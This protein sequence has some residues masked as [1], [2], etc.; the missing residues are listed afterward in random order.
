MAETSVCCRRRIAFS[1]NGPRGGAPQLLR[2]LAA[3]LRQRG[4]PCE[5]HAATFT[6]AAPLDALPG[7]SSDTNPRPALQGQ[8]RAEGKRLG[9]AGGAG[10]GLDPGQ[11][12][13]CVP[14]PEQGAKRRRVDAGREGGCMRMA[15]LQEASGAFVVSASVP[16]A[17]SEAA[18]RQFAALVGALKAELGQAGGCWRVGH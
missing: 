2:A 9:H 4:V 18:A 14:D 8:Q 17:C 3:A 10:P 15:V 5:A 7:G 16:A 12:P 11:A 1:V 13:G 6:L